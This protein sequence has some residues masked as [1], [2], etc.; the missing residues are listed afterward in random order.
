[1]PCSGTRA[2]PSYKFLKTKPHKKQY[3]D[4]N[5]KMTQQCSINS[6]QYFRTM[7]SLGIETPRQ[8]RRPEAAFYFFKFKNIPYIFFNK[9]V[10]PLTIF[11]VLDIYMVYKKERYKKRYKG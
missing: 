8:S 11:V 6:E 3:T 4:N 10:F 2:W 5:N 9:I 1:M 7:E